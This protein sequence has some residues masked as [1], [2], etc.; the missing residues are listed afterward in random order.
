MF[1]A[2]H[3]ISLSWHTSKSF[4][5]LSSTLKNREEA[6]ESE[7]ILQYQYATL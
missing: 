7:M 6:K 4:P 1:I 2:A 3:T 5:F